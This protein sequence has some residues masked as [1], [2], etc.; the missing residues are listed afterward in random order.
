MVAILVHVNIFIFLFLSG[1]H[2]YWVAG[3]QWSLQG[4]NPEDWKDNVLEMKRSHF[5]FST[6]IVA[7]GLALF[8]LITYNNYYVIDLGLDKK[9]LILATRLIGA[10]FILRA[11][12]DFN[13]CGIFKKKSN[14]VFASRDS[15]IYVPL[16]LYLG[17][18]S[19]LITF[20]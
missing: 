7:V 8:G 16:C 15:R 20:L 4:A 17:F 18:T 6:F 5:Q 12:G 11:I 1:L 9:W 3:G 10:I 14:S 2:L 19:L 13:V